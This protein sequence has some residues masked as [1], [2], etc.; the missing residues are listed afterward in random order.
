MPGNKIYSIEDMFNFIEDIANDIDRYKCE[1]Q[2]VFDWLFKY[3]D[4]QSCKRLIEFL[5]LEH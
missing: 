5:G 1:R 3:H 2:K 4:N